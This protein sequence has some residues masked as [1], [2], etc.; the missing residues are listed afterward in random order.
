[1]RRRAQGGVSSSFA[2]RTQLP[3]GLLAALNCSCILTITI[4]NNNPPH[5]HAP[6]QIWENFVKELGHQQVIYRFGKN[7]K[8]RSTDRSMFWA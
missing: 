3:T 1:M 2:C 7:T 6:S 4:N 8:T 5:T